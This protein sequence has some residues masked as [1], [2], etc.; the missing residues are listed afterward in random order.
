MHDTFHFIHPWW[1]LTLLPLGLLVVRAISGRDRANAWQNVVEARLMPLLQVGR[2]G[3][4]SPQ[5]PW[6]LGAGWLIAALALADPTWERRPQPVFQST[7]A[8]V[9]ILDLST[10]MNADDLRPSRLVRARYKIEDVLAQAT[11]GQTGLV[12][13]AGAAFTVAPLTRDG[14]TIRSL[15]KVLEPDLMPKQGNRADLGLAKAGELLRQ[16]GLTSGQVLL[17]A[18]GVDP[19]RANATD[20]AAADLRRDGFTVSVLGIG[21]EA[22]APSAAA[23]GTRQRDASGNVLVSRLDAVAL[24]SVATAGGGAYRTIS[25]NGDSLRALLASGGSGQAVERTPVAAKAAAWK[26]QGPVLILFLL[27]LAALAFRR[28]WLLGFTLAAA[29]AV[30]LQ[31]AEAATWSDV[32]QR[33]DQQ[34]A[35]ALA[36][37]DYAKAEQA[38]ADANDPALR[39]SAAYRMGDYQRAQDAFSHARG[40][41]ADYNRGNALARQG[42]YQD[43]VTAYDKSIAE[44]PVNQDARANKAAVE[45]LLKSQ[46]P[47]QQ[48]NGSPKAGDGQKE[49]DGAAKG[50][51]GGQKQKDGD[52][53]KSDDGRQQQAG[54]QGSDAGHDRRQGQGQGDTSPPAAEQQAQPHPTQG[55]AGA[56]QHGASAGSPPEGGVASSKAERQAQGSTAQ[57]SQAPGSAQPS[58]PAQRSGEGARTTPSGPRDQ[59]AKA[60]KRLDESGHDTGSGANPPANTGQAGQADRAAG[61]QGD[62]Q[63]ATKGA[64]GRAQPLESEERLAAEQWLRRIPDDPGGLLRR[65]FLYQ[66][67]QHRQQDP[68]DDL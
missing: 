34:A 32:W 30:P 25:D 5:I 15:L 43:A 61:P 48:K 18:D 62:R 16:A 6:L 10:S 36:G 58:S 66:Y 20:R 1:L 47:A 11:E 35:H 39:G 29:I 24:R 9:V 26:E 19:G 63:P 8:R 14:N 4:A 22:G 27:P 12:A 13:Y 60:V 28:R 2:S 65:K 31:S 68:S 38:A 21:K 41:D 57:E 50:S 56:D 55:K 53:S 51:S 46:P 3:R 17:I 37:G 23:S 64:S 52:P 33:P 67:R 42:R 44:R 40:A 54:G 7:A 49:Q 45:A 59:F